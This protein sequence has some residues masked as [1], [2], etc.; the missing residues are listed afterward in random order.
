LPFAGRHS[1]RLGAE[2]D[3]DAARRCP[4]ACIWLAMGVSIA[5]VRHFGRRSTVV[6]IRFRPDHHR[7]PP[8]HGD[9]A[10]GVAPRPTI[11]CWWGC[12]R[13]ADPLRPGRRRRAAPIEWRPWELPRSKWER[14]SSR[15][16]G[17]Q[18]HHPSIS[19]GVGETRSRE[20]FTLAVVVVARGIAVGS[21]QGSA[22]RWILAVLFFVSPYLIN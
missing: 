21:A 18:P 2:R 14:G 3:R 6:L 7:P 1:G 5:S 15:D 19:Q 17:R 4:G 22:S 10:A 20:L 13:D 16:G 8:P 11:C 12:L 9:L